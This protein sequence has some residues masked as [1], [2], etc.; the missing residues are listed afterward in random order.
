MNPTPNPNKALWEKGDFTRIAETMRDS[1][2]KL[3]NSLG[4]TKGMRVLDVGGG[5]G[6]TA[7]P[8]ATLGA[9]V[10]CVDI[11]S[12]L[13]AAGNKR[14]QQ[15]GLTNVRFQEGD[16]C[17]LAGVPDTSCDLVLSV[18][19]AMFAPKPMD[20]AKSLVRVTKPGGRIIMANW[21]P[22]DPTLVAQILKVSAAYSPPPPEGFVSPM[23][24]GVEKNIHERFG[25]A[26]VAAERIACV[27]DTYTFN[28][29]G[30]PAAFVSEFRNY[31]G[32]TMNAFAAAEQNGKADD[33]ERE[34]VAL[35]TA[36]NQGR[37][38]ICSIPAT[39]MR[40]TVQV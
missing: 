5:D 4:I 18:F 30:S 32:P 35:F 20:V 33:L 26:G 36:Q 23:L 27:P 17:D 11:S 40:V 16:A 25:A 2:E 7:I 15:M 13:V 8:A 22:G 6:T 12:P 19:G 9:D 10:L 14:A 24:W 31:Y 34:L 28:F 1:G 29:N 38:G 21:I 39:F 3:V 37:N